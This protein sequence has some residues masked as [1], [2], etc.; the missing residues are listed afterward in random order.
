MKKKRLYSSAFWLYRPPLP[1]ATTTLPM[2][3]RATPRTKN[4]N[5][6]V[7]PNAANLEMP[8]LDDQ[9][10]DIYSHYVTYNGTR[11]LNYTVDW[12]KEKSIHVGWLSFLPI[13]RRA[14][15]GTATTGKAQNGTAPYGR[16]SLP[17]RPGYSGRRAHGT[18]RLPGK[19]LQPGAPFAP[20]PTG[21]SPKDANGQTFYLSN[22]SPQMGRVQPGRLGGL[23][24]SGTK[25]GGATVP[26]VTRSSS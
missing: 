18:G 8:R 9:T 17:S 13:Q 11:V 4:A 6:S 2:E 19:R 26:F 15:P 25:L 16:G 22:M 7:I 20:R 23:G 14:L 3:P 21:C 12:H 24:R 5:P 1:P 10:G